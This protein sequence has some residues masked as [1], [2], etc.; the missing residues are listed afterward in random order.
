MNILVNWYQAQQTLAAAKKTEL[1]LRK[2]VV[3]EYFP[4]LD[5]G[6]NTC[7]IDGD[8]TLTA[9]LPYNYSVDVDTLDAGLEHIP[10]TKQEKL[11]T[12]KPSM[13]IAVYRKLTKKAR[14]GFTAECVTV[15]P[16]T[17]SLKITTAS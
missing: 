6:A 7:E 15:K 11:I 4:E 16:G 14:N 13:S 1:A 5:E 3:E 12:W 10:A 2:Q 9:T 17:P 8:A